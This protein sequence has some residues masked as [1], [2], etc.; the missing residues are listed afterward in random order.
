LRY[1][2][3]PLIVFTKRWITIIVVSYAGGSVVNL[4]P[5]HKYYVQ[6]L[7]STGDREA[8]MLNLFVENATKRMPST[9]A[10]GDTRRVHTDDD[11]GKT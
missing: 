11:D 7:T 9:A 2:F 8:M 3:A 5:T 6:I 1:N 10:A 4:L